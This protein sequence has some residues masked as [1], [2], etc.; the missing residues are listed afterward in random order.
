MASVT[1][2]PNERDSEQGAITSRAWQLPN[3]ESSNLSAQ[4][5]STNDAL[6]NVRLVSVKLGIRKD[7]PV[8]PK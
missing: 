4:R 8:K 5:V 1:S 7:S 2:S 3:A 6:D